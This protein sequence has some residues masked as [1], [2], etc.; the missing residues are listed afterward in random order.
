VQG[1]DKGLHNCAT[2]RGGQSSTAVQIQ[3]SWGFLA[4]TRR[5]SLEED[6]R[7]TSYIWR[8]REAVPTGG[9]GGWC[10]Q[11]LSQSPLTHQWNS[12]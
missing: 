1:S 10:Q 5:Q 6:C 3:G 7:K 9:E 4:V 12:T 11:C 8:R 2:L